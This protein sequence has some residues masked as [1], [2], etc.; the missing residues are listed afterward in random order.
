MSAVRC[1]HCGSALPLAEAA[2]QPQRLACTRCGRA[3]E[4]EV[5]PALARGLAAGRAGEVSIG[6]EARCFF[7]DE[8]RAE[9]V[10]DG[11]GRYLC[12]TCE[13]RVGE[14]LLCP[15]C[16]ETGRTRK[17]LPQ[18]ERWR[19]L[20]TSLALW[21]ALLSFVLT[22]LPVGAVGGPAAIVLAGVGLYRRGSVTGSRGVPA[23]VLAIVLGLALTVFWYAVLFGIW[24]VSEV[25]AI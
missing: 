12:A 13:I 19:L 17:T 20:P 15:E 24:F 8:K 10:C 22:P 1:P 25:G 3:V 14:R 11:C 4:V 7:H 23:A 5:F 16:F 9:A 6:D 2:V 18:L 21:I